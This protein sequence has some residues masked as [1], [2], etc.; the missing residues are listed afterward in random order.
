VGSDLAAYNSLATTTN[1]VT[2]KA[3]AGDGTNG[4]VLNS[5]VFYN[6]N[7]GDGSSITVDNLAGTFAG[8]AT[9]SDLGLDGLSGTTYTADATHNTG[10]ITLF[11]TS[12]FTVEAGAD[13]FTLA[14]LGMGGGDQGT[15]FYDGGTVVAAIANTNI[16]F[17]LNGTNVAVAIAGGDNA[18]TIVTKLQTAITAASE[19]VTVSLVSGNIHFENSVS[20]DNTPI[21]VDSFTWTNNPVGDPTIFGFS[22]FTAQ[23]GGVNG[24]VVADDGK[25]TYEDTSAG[26]LLPGYDYFDELDTTGSFDIWIY[27]NDGSLALAQPV[28]VSLE[29]AYSLNDVANIIN[30]TIDAATNSSGWLT[31]SNYA[32]SLRL[33][34]DASHQFAFA[35]DTSNFLQIAGLNTFFS[36]NSAASISLNSMVSGDL[37]TLAAATVGP[38]GQIFRGDNTNSLKITN[39]QHDEYVTFTGGARNTLD[40]FY[41][42]LVGQ[43][44]N[45]TR[46]ISHSYESTVLINKQVKEMRDSVSGVSLDEEM[47]NLVKYQHAY[48]A[49]A[50]LITM[51]DE[52]LQTLLDSMR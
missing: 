7:E 8:A 46:T 9:T 27:N 33:T 28:T 21:V 13:D 50:R 14:Q 23:I 36:G 38:Q 31:A 19:P 29:R 6:Q 5:I 18:A 34:P 48:T 30:K 24:D 11:S 44:A 43:V 52:M 10:E 26:P 37:N 49:A 40:G 47:A 12:T 2:V 15:T 16:A 41:N 22:N 45:T 25:F 42:I 51:S 17:N 4:G 1:P 35:N 32:N 3:R 20:G 39:I